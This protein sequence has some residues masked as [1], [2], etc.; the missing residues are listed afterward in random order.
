M[1]FIDKNELSLSQNGDELMLTIKN[2][3]CSFILPA[4]LCSREITGAKYVN[5]HLEI[6]F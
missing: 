2:E 4:K 1:P 3:K 6:Y 5:D